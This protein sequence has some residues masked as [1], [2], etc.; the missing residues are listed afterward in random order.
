MAIVARTA[1]TA[2]AA[3]LSGRAARVTHT[4]LFIAALVVSPG[5]CDACAS[6]C[7]QG[8][9]A[10]AGIPSTGCSSN[11]RPSSSSCPSQLLDTLPVC[12]DFK[13][14]QCKRPQCKYVH[15]V[16]EY[17]EVSEGKVTVCRDAVKGKCARPLCKYY[18]LPILPHLL[19]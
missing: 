10:A 8:G 1:S 9:F 5:V 12:R 18:H 4:L 13:A 6:G 16:E 11:S 19:V 7:S 3:T 15:L 2:R 14:G 17:V